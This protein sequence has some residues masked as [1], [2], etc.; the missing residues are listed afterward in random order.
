MG[1]F[2]CLK[3]EMATLLDTPPPNLNSTNIFL[4]SIWGQAAKFKDHQYFRLYSALYIYTEGPHVTLIIVNLVTSCWVDHMLLICS[5][6]FIPLENTI[7]SLPGSSPAFL[8]TVARRGGEESLRRK[9]RAQ[10]VLWVDH[11]LLIPLNVT[12]DAF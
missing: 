6:V 8:A 11:V 5:V 1:L 12:V 4:R 9:L 3:R 2:K 10:T 7:V